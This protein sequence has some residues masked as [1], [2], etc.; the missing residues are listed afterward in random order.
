MINNWHVPRNK[1]KL[2]PIVLALSEFS[3]QNLGSTWA[4]DKKRQL[5]Y[6]EI[7]EEKGLKKKGKRRNQEGGGARTYEA[8]VY[9]LGLIFDETDTN[10]TRLTMLGEA[11]LNWEPPVPL[12]TKQLMLFQYPSPYSLRKGVR[13]NERFKIRPFRFLIKLLLDER[14]A[15]DSYNQKPYLT[16]PEI[17]C[18]IS[19]EA[20]DES[21]KCY[22]HIVERILLFRRIGYEAL[23]EGFEQNVP[24][25][26]TGIR[27]RERTIRALEDN[28]ITFINYLEY[29]QLI[30]RDTRNLPIYIPENR[31]EKVKDI[32]ND[33]TKM[34]RINEST[35]KNKYWKEN[36]QR[37]YG[38]LPGK[39][40]D[41]RRFE[42]QKLTEDTVMEQ[43]VRKD[44]LDYAKNVPIAEISQELIETIAD[45]TGLH[46]EYVEEKL[47]KL[48]VDTFDLFERNYIDMAFSGRNLASEFEQ[49]TLNVFAEL[50]FYTQH[51]GNK[52]RHPDIFVKSDHFSGIIDNKAYQV[53]SITHDYELK[54][55]NSYIP[56][57]KKTHNNLSF[58]MYIAGGFGKNSSNQVRH[59]ANKSGTN[60]CGIKAAD[61]MRLLKKHKKQTINQQKLK[62]LFE[63]NRIITTQ[64]ILSL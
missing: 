31:I 1:R 28:A 19:V 42:D 48:N 14:L 3:E 36:F 60:G 47:D 63:C 12:L 55:I 23:H 51:V 15:N 45:K 5:T 25:S 46:L 8:W 17:G 50:G 38:L 49:A 21:T 59:I 53:F 33:D 58:F 4:K 57:Y 27:T 44:F 61:L 64:D 34:Q 22:E 20:E 39:N 18:I 54:M 52:P 56:K 26:K 30:V 11:L 6:E 29:S 43:M 13:I 10:K 41:I 35:K 16:K 62:V 37:S 40:K 24:S 9:A 2:Y 7:L 32:L